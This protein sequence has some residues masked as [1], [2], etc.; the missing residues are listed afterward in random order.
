M[1]KRILLITLA[2][3]AVALAGCGKPKAKEITSLQRKEAATLVGDADFASTL[4][5]HAKA[6][7]LLAKAVALCPDNG[8]YWL[9]LGATRAR[10]KQR[11]GAK[12]AYQGALAAY[13]ADA[14][15]AP[16]EAQPVLQQIYA[17]ALLGRTSDARA[18]LEKAK[19]L[20]PTDHAVKA[21]AGGQFEQAIASGAFK[22]VAL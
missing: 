9:S 10:L 20:F 16:K 21:F 15:K 2:A 8:E 7:G 11:D 14:K 19:K 18:L 4:R 3:A 17:L 5:D 13:E 22:E 6:E 12:T 1:M